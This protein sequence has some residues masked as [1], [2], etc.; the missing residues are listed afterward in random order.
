LKAWKTGAVIGGLLGLFVGESIIVGHTFPVEGLFLGAIIGAL[1]VMFSD[2]ISFF[3]F[4][5]YSLIPFYYRSE[6]MEPFF[7]PP[8]LYLAAIVILAVPL[9]S[10]ILYYSVV[11]LILKIESKETRKNIIKTAIMTYLIYF[12]FTFFYNHGGRLC[13]ACPLRRKSK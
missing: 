7:Y 4:L 1:F 9:G 13:W 5:I 11:R 6:I 2:L 12:S 3:S 10:S 8:N